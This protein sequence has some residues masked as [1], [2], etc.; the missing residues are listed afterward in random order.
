MLVL[1]GGGYDYLAP[2]ES[3]VVADWLGD[4]GHPAEVLPYPVRTR[5]PAPL[6][7]V[8]RR[9]AELRAD[10]VRR[11]GIIGFSAGGH[12]A[13]QA[14]LSARP[15]EPCRVDAAVL[16]YPVVSMLL[17][18]HAGSRGNLLGADATPAARAETSL[19]C[20][21][22][23]YAPPTFIWHTADDDVVPVQHSYLLARALAGH[24]V[25]HELHV[26]PSG[27]HGL[28]LA[29]DRPPVSSWTSLCLDWLTG[30]MRPA[31]DDSS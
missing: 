12:L 16:C 19:E 27:R 20:L 7:A 9:I 6:D 18:T 3:Q 31:S 17:D 21:V 2:H 14:A 1:P 24:D 8:R 13:G 10:G 15:G 30:I 26:F 11:V 22:T 28:G 25:P 5:Q 29:V 23:P 4:S